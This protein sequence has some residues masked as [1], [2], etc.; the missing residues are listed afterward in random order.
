[1]L[2]Y[3]RHTR[4]EARR[5]TEVMTTGFAQV[6]C[7]EAGGPEPGVGCAGRG[8]LSAFELLEHLG[9]QQLGFD[10]TLYDVLG[11]VVCGGFAVPLREAYADQIFIVTSGEFMALYAAN[12]ILRGVRNF[13]GRGPRVGGILLNRRGLE[14]ETAR[15][16]RFADAVQL[17]ILMDMPRDVHFMEAERQGATLQEAF[18]DLALSGRF[19]D[20]A[21]QVRQGLPVYPALPLEPDALEDV[22]LGR[23]GVGA[24]T[25]ALPDIPPAPPATE[26]PARRYF[27]KSMRHQE[28]LHGCAYNAAVHMALQVKG[29]LTLVHGP[30][31]CAFISQSGAAGSAR[32]TW[33]RTGTW[34]A[35][36]LAQ[37]LACTAM[38]ER[39]AIFGG[40]EELGAGLKAAA[41]ARPRALF[42][43]TT[44]SSGIIGDDLDQALTQH[45][46][47]L[48]GIPVVPLKTDGNL[49]GDYMQGILDAAVTLGRHLIDPDVVEEPGW[50]NIVGEKNLATNAETNYLAMKAVL[51]ALELQVNCRF[52]RNTDVEA[53]R[54]FQRAGV[55]LLA[56]ED[57]MGRGLRS[58]LEA[59]CAA[60]FLPGAFPVGFEASARWV[61]ALGAMTARE[62]QATQ[63]VAQERLRYE[64]GLRQLRPRLAGKRLMIVTPN[65]QVD[66]V[67]ELAQDLHM[68]V[69]QAGIL[70]S[71][72]EDTFQSR[73]EGRIPIRLHY[74]REDRDRDIRA[75]HPDLTLT[76]TLW[77]GQ[78]SDR[79]V[80]RFP[81][82]PDA[83][84]QAALEEARRWSR[85]LSLPAK[86]G[87][88]DDLQM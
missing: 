64:Q 27:S 54:G 19:R 53:I 47:L 38:D 25:P 4:P 51:D 63:L 68:E 52:I 26:T 34:Q 41:A 9:V 6:A 49:T 69:V 7:V 23:K 79:K 44:C 84:F 36:S 10:L 72:W 28:V 74:T 22:V 45:K 1:V 65:H 71:A 86:E 61:T 12:N 83:G 13:E 78:P 29:A 31:S 58:F 59:H 42:V 3:L 56:H 55:N 77:P 88:R 73:F 37:S 2:D 60:R 50:V 66:W 8:I 48:E 30:K 24:A 80:E 14:D 21:R 5:L 32:R 18:P 62:R 85:A 11:D 15:V 43:A 82:C 17:P 35:P 16:Q 67:L 75:L 81:Y 70:E 87:W 46:D 33:R 57:A 20:L 39:T 76:H 40:M